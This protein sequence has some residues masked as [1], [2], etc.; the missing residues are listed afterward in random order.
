MYVRISLIFELKKTEFWIIFL[1]FLVCLYHID[2]AISNYIIENRPSWE[3]HCLV[4]SLSCRQVPKKV[5]HFISRNIDSN[6]VTHSICTYVLFSANEECNSPTRQHTE[7][8]Q[9]L[10]LDS[11]AKLAWIH[12]LSNKLKVWPCTI[13]FSS[14][15][16][17]IREICK[18]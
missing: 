9:E 1:E 5:V 4:L 14:S 16:D 6:A 13:H 17:D 3:C 18:D 2:F 7:V 10:K 15:C 11:Y 8:L 12:D